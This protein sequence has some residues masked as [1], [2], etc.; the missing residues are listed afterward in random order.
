[1]HTSIQ[2]AA[3]SNDSNITDQSNIISNMVFDLLLIKHN[4]NK[5]KSNYNIGSI[6]FHLNVAVNSVQ[7]DLD[8]MCVKYS[9][10]ILIRIRYI[11]MMHIFRAIYNRI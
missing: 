7:N 9:F 3:V 11:K 8:N 10:P 1:M 4:S 2:F 5:D 6:L